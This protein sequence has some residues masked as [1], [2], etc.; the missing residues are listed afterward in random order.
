MT[1]DQRTLLLDK[2]RAAYDAYNDRDWDRFFAQLDADY[3]FVP[4]EEGVA[5]RGREDVL[6]YQERWLAAWDEFAIEVDDLELASDA[7]RIF[8]AL[9]YRGTAHGDGP[10][11]DGRFFRVGEVRGDAYLRT[12]E[13]LDEDEARR[14]AGLLV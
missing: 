14:A 12:T 4:V 5:Y 6:A 13:Y 7:S 10:S 1:V 8:V 11:V 9:R 3:E 2:A